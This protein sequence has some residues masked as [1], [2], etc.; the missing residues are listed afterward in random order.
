MPG[1]S[2]ISS[3]DAAE[4][5]FTDPNFF[6]SAA[7]R[8]EADA[9]YDTAIARTGNAAERAYLARAKQHLSHPDSGG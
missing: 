2:A 9:A 4:I 5:A 1:T 7:R 3:S 6:S 8:A